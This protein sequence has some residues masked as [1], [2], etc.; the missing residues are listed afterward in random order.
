[1][2]VITGNVRVD[3]QILKTLKDCFVYIWIHQDWRKSETKQGGVVG[4]G[5]WNRWLNCKCEKWAI[6]V[7]D[8][9]LILI[10]IDSIA[11]SQPLISDGQHLWWGVFMIY[12][13]DSWLLSCHV[14]KNN[15]CLPRS[16][17]HIPNLFFNFH[18]IHVF[19]IFFL[20]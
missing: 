20:V 18:F 1:M 6:C 8:P 11:K 5:H 9:H 12:N 15:I 17:F 2:N 4:V 3:L 14:N 19:L 16:S 7:M 10:L 13:P